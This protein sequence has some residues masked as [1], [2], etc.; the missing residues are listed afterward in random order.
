MTTGLVFGKFYP[1]HIGHKMLIEWAAR[2]CGK[3]IVFVIGNPDEAIPANVRA[4]WIETIHNPNNERGIDV[5]SIT[6]DQREDYEDMEVFKQWDTIIKNAIG[7]RKIDFLFTSEPKYG[8][9]C[10]QLLGAKHVLVDFERSIIPI[11]G[12][13]VR[14]NPYKNWSYLDLPVR[15]FYAK[16]VCLLGAESTGTTTTTQALA[17]IFD[18]NWVPEYGRAYTI[19]KYRTGE[20]WKTGDFTHIAMRQLQLEDDAAKLCNRILFCD[21]DALTTQL[22]HRH[23]MGRDSRFVQL[24][25]NANN[26]ENHYALTFLTYPDIPW[27]NDGLRDSPAV[28][29]MMHEW[30]LEAVKD[31]PEPV[32]HLMGSLE[33]RLQTATEAITRHIG[34]TNISY[35]SPK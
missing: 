15:E 1:P 22:F 6:T 17:E 9:I 3:L 14:E 4:D 23:Y 31:R 19:P 10:A 28:R 34:F 18:T 13:L 30:F 25:V 26:K 11:S 5:I 8:D 2:S 29:Q 32:I 21:T 35:G 16:R 12:T 24:E 27:V 7:N 20:G 33:A